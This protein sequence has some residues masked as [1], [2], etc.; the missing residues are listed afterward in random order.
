MTQ[1]ATVTLQFVGD[2]KQVL[3][4]MSK[5]EEGLKRVSAESDRATSSMERGA[6]AA[7][8]A[9]Q[10][11]DTSLKKIQASAMRLGQTG[12]IAGKQLSEGARSADQSF[13]RFF[14]TARE[15]RA[16]LAILAGFKLGKEIVTSV[17]EL[18][19]GYTN[20]SSKIRTVSQSE[21]EL[22]SVRAKLF[23][24]T[25]RTRTEFD[26]TVTLYARITRATERLNLSEQQRL[27]LVETINKAYT[28]SGATVQ[29]ATNSIIQLTQG[30]ASGTLR[31][32]EFNSVAE[33][34]P[35]ILELLS[36][37]LG[38]TRG[39][40]RAMAAQGKLTA[41][42]VTAAILQGQSEIDNQFARVQTTISGA[43]V[44]VVNAWQKWLGEMNKASGLSREVA[45]SLTGVADNMDAIASTAILTAFAIV[46]VFAG[47]GLR[48]I[49]TFAN[50][51]RLQIV[52]SYKQVVA[53]QEAARAEY[54]EAQAKV[55]STEAARVHIQAARQDTL[56]SLKSVQA[57]LAIAAAKTAE[58]EQVSLAATVEVAAAEAHVQ[59][60]T[61]AGAQSYALKELAAAQ[62]RAVA[63]EESVTAAMQA[64][65]ALRQ[66]VTALTAQQGAAVNELAR[67]SV[68]ET[69][70]MAARSAAYNRLTTA[71]IGLSTAQTPLR[72]AFSQLATVGKS[73]FTLIGGWPTVV[74]AAGYATYEWLRASKDT[75]DALHDLSAA[76]EQLK[77]K[78]DDLRR[79]I[80]QNQDKERSK[81]TTQQQQIENTYSLIRASISSTEANRDYFLS[82]QE[83]TGSLGASAAVAAAYQIKLLFLKNQL[84]D[85]QEAQAAYNKALKEFLELRDRKNAI[86]AGP[87]ADFAGGTNIPKKA[88][89]AYTKKINEETVALEKNRI[90]K[91]KGKLAG[92][93]Y[94]AMQR[95]SLSSISQI[96]PAL[97]T[98][99]EALAKLQTEQERH[100]ASVKE[101]TK[102]QRAARAAAK[103]YARVLSDQM[104]QTKKVV[105]A[106]DHLRESIA[107]KSDILSGLT[108]SEAN[109][110]SA[111]RE[112][113]REIAK[114]LE[115]GPPTE[116]I[117]KAI[118][119][120]YE[121]QG[122]LK[123]Q[124]TQDNPLLSGNVDLVLELQKQADELKG[125]TKAQIEYNAKALIANKLKDEAIRLGASE[126]EANQLLA[127]RLK[128][129]AE[130]RDNADL[131]EIFTK[132]NDQDTFDKLIENIGKVED[133]LKTATDPKTVDQLKEALGNLRH[134]MI[135]GIVQSSVSALRSIQSMT[136]EGSRAYQA[137]EIAINALTVVQAISAVL[138]Q[139][140]GDPY[141]AFA[142][143]AAMA[144]AVASLGVSISNFR[145]SG[146]KDTAAERQATQGTGSVLGDASAKSDSI[147]K[148]IDITAN[149]TSKLVGINRG[150]LNALVSL[151]TALGAAG[152]QLARGAADANFSYT[153]T[154]FDFKDPLTQALLGG[155]SK[156]TDQGIVI[157]GGALSDL[158][159]NVAVGAYQEVKSR[160]WLFGSTKTHTSITDV[161]EQFGKDFQLVISSIVDTVK[162]GAVALGLLPEEVQ[163]RLDAFQVEAI[164]ISLKGLSAEEQQKEI[165]AVFSKLF[166]D[167]AGSIVPFIG[168]FQQ[169]GEG[170]G[171]TLVRIAT[172]VQ[173]A[174]EAFQ[175]LGIAVDSSD[176]EQFA[177]ISD[178]LIQAAGGLDSFISGMQSFVT[179]FS[180]NQNQLDSAGK[181]LS[182]A[183]EQV[184]LTVPA[185]RD[186]M[187]ELMKSLDATTEAGREQIA[188][189]LRLSD[190]AKAYYDG[191][192]KQAKELADASQY[193]DSIGVTNAASQFS[194]SMESI[195]QSVVKAIAAANTLAQAQGKDGAS[196][197]Q[198]A[199]IHKWAAQQ[200]AA[201]IRALQQSIQDLKA[202]LYGG[203]PGSLEGI[204]A[205]IQ[206]LEQSSGTLSSGF[207]NLTDAGNNMIEEWRSGI[208]SLSDYLNQSLFGDLSPLNPEQQL[209]EAQHQLD[210]AIAAAQGGDATALQS[211]PQLMQQ[212]AELL[213]GSQAS[214]QDYNSVIN[215]YRTQLQGLL[216][217]PGPAGSGNP[218][219]I[220]QVQASAQL[221][222]LY[223]KRDKLLAEQEDEQRRQLAEQLAEN[224]RDLAAL[225]GVTVLD[226]LTLQGVQLDKLAEDLGVDLSNLN[227]DTVQ[228][229]G[230]MAT[231][232]GIGFGDLTGALGLH[233]SDLNG[234]LTELAN[235][236][237]IDLNHLTVSSVE[238]LAELA[239]S[240]GADLGDLSDGLGIS[241]GELTDSNSLLSQGLGDTIDQL[242]DGT[243][244]QLKP[245]FEAIVNATDDASA[246]DAVHNLEDAVNL[247][248]PDIK[249]QLAPYLTNVFPSTAL[250]NLDY[251]SNISDLSQTQIDILRDIAKGLDVPGYAVGTPYVNQDH[252]AT[253]HTGEMVVDAD[254]ANAFRKYGI[255]VNN[256]NS[257]S[258]DE[259]VQE[260]K[261]LRG[262]IVELRRATQSSG[263][264]V[265]GAIQDT[266]R[267]NSADR[268][269]QLKRL[270]E[271]M[272]K[273]RRA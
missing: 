73:L 141:T 96:P 227:G 3:D 139:A 80:E 211:L 252:L 32:E 53:A 163:K 74:L 254:S 130:V 11:T 89:Y 187:W 152:N 83:V 147:A 59:A 262:E 123:K 260:V 54:E 100:K 12:Q 234:G 142:R 258:S 196:T 70:T 72:A 14:E 2:P 30:L 25:Q 126:G 20:L 217:L 185:T 213:R 31:G 44:R 61:S 16:T 225:A 91:E 145:H 122:L 199:A 204:N 78:N 41:D 51:Q 48:A 71:T 248:G 146:Y 259:L 94:E 82:T 228:A 109:Y 179:N 8:S 42:V 253:V 265:T 157:F 231:S 198:L 129:L 97:E 223:E 6:V 101:D 153:P 200:T 195:H 156:I 69:E 166:D 40:L 119:A 36:K 108:P 159:N 155:S 115:Q 140:Q 202:Q 186:G 50:A 229:L 269:F 127:K 120:L 194:T 34:G 161:S 216:G 247:L 149:A 243:R 207:G 209:T 67:L 17:I 47:R 191:L 134:T 237:G 64:E 65:S 270:G 178:G 125:L 26:S 23:E 4:A 240:L 29:E 116:E 113:N 43:S 85:V 93:Q 218:T 169:A 162:K 206:K 92:L 138:N 151:Q 165:E 182:S 181:A 208:Q 9:Y 98:Q 189:L 1:A 95:L 77:E 154:Q 57:S 144:A 38:K 114:F 184:G 172:E 79:S 193:L 62:S 224:I 24:I 110:N 63:A 263:D 21:Y 272:K 256:S 112:T 46:T 226:E 249:N 86:E 15:V 143:M 90:A 27:N 244:D 5:M 158:L 219:Q 266:G 160:S 121:R 239:N 132:W 88:Y 60:A 250:T 177:Q 268:E 45:D 246:T 257:V 210:Q 176:P 84:G 7:S 76:T 52:E 137:M 190:T 203:I 68:L 245:L 235:G 175:Q 197:V 28:L 58:A 39:E 242:P 22:S 105:D 201:A 205:E 135:T 10:K 128:K 230:N 232:L 118:T 215:D 174:K 133:A 267:K 19:D 66:R 192:D 212:F 241:L 55:A 214:G 136:K 233:L 124:A 111:L 106:N 171:Q 103:E 236:L 188:T 273:S 35:I 264:K 183:F 173:V 221:Q 56:E 164:N 99:L 102:A 255:P 271:D 150:M 75:T 107:K 37:S 170:L 261:K 148:S 81:L 238:T 87:P 13:K 180:S 131:A 49:L 18:S 222:A 168:Q 251:L 117:L 167:I 104:Q 33:Q 220:V